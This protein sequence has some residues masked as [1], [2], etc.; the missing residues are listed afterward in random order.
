LV[1]SGGGG[2]IE[3][4][5]L[6]RMLGDEDD[7]GTKKDWKIR[8]G[9]IC[10]TDSARAYANLSR[11]PYEETQGRGVLSVAWRDGTK[12]G[13]K[14][15]ARKARERARGQRKAAGDISAASDCV[16]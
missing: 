16:T 4:C 11:I 7:D 10:H 1:E 13:R 5:E 15:Q 6:W 8:W 12:K 9:T 14:I 3:N 2:P